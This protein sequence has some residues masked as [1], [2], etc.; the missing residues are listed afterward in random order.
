MKVLSLI[1]TP[2]DGFTGTAGHKLSPGVVIGLGLIAA[3]KVQ[4]GLIS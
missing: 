4:T 2:L 1:L 3:T